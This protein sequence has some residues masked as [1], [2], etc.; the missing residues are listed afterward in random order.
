MGA[1]EI[2]NRAR[3]SLGE[4]CINECKAYCC[5]KGYLILKA[6]EVDLVVKG[7]KSLKKVEGGFSLNF[8]EGGCPSLK[9]NKCSVYENRP[10]TC[11]DFPIF[12][13]G[14]YVRISPRCYGFT[15][16]LLYPFIK[17]FKKIKMI[18]S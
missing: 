15:S 10:Q 7:K 1:E 9:D 4:Y 2:A 3:N 6:K 8:N 13:K 17:E 18:I 12:I 14:K 11:R 5:K 16:G